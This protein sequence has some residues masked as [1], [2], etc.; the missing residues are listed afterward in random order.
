MF[1]PA[2]GD[3]TTLDVLAGITTGDYD[4][5]TDKGPLINLYFEEHEVKKQYLCVIVLQDHL[6]AQY[7]SSQKEMLNDNDIGFYRFKENSFK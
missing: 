3:P 6:S 5:L 7:L 2:G 1:Y 4:C